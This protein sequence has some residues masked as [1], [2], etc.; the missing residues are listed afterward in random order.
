MRS[1]MILCAAAAA[2]VVGC[3]SVGGRSG[4]GGAGDMAV[5]SGPE[6]NPPKLGTV[7]LQSVFFTGFAMATAT[8]RFSTYDGS[9]T[10]P[11]SVTTA[12]ACRVRSCPRDDMGATVAGPART[13]VGAGTVTLTGPAGAMPLA[14]QADGSYQLSLGSAKPWEGGESFHVAAT[15]DVVPAFDVSLPASSRPRMTSPARP[16]GNAPGPT[17]TRTAGLPITWKAASPGTLTIT[18]T[19]DTP[20]AFLALQCD[21]PTS[22]GSYTIAPEA[23]AALPAGGT[24]TTLTANVSNTTT[25]M[26]GDWPVTFLVEN[27]PNDDVQDMP[28]IMGVTLQ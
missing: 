20:G 9:A 3:D 16:A 2:A 4:D 7:T 22:A 17:V 14:V 18:L 8:A 19:S 26:A 5:A 28:W 21:A 25:L 13:N 24:G 15:G 12:G 1:A 11:C 10:G 6:A 27:V 23:L